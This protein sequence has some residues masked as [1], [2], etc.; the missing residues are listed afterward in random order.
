MLYI[1]NLIRIIY[2]YDYCQGEIGRHGKTSAPSSIYR[3][4]ERYGLAGLAL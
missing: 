3:W 2:S 4:L 1:D